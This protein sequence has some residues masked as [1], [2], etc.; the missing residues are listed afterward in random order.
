METLSL[1]KELE[2]KVFASLGQCALFRALKPEQLPQLV[3]VAELSRYEP[4]E[5]IVR[6]GEP[7]DSFWS[8]STAWPRS[9]ST[10]GRRRGRRARP[11]PAALA[12]W[13]R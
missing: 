2:P 3:K 13:A 10:A 5:T 1:T 7:S 12:A 4:D 6:Q 9:P 11:D 8:S